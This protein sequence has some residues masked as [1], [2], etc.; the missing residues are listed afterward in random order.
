VLF[1][2][3]SRLASFVPARL[4]LAALLLMVTAG[5]ARPIDRP[6]EGARPARAA[7]DGASKVSAAPPT[8]AAKPAEPAASPTLVVAVVASPSPPVAAVTASPQTVAAASPVPPG[9]NPILGNLQPGNQAVVP[10]GT[11]NIG[12]RITTTAELAEVVLTVNGVPVQPQVTQQDERTWLVAHASGLPAGS[13]RAHLTARDQHGRAGG[14]GWQFEVAGL[15]RASP[16]AR[17]P[18]G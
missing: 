4:L 5:C 7:E 10:A 18:V 9:R 17:S 1:S 2:A 15:P 6:L 14:F 11:V 12:A 13:Y 8:L 16:S 3:R